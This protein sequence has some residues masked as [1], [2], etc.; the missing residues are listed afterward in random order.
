[1]ANLIRNFLTLLFTVF[2]LTTSPVL[3]F[4]SD[5]LV[6]SLRASLKIAKSDSVKAEISLSL[7]SYTLSVDYKESL[8]YA[9]Q[10]VSFAMEAKSHL[11]LMKGYKAVASVFFYMGVYDKA[12]SFFE[13]CA[14]EAAL[15]NEKF[16][17][18]NCQIN[19]ALIYSALRQYQRAIAI[20]EN[21]QPRLETAYKKAGKE[22]PVADLISIKLN[23]AYNYE[24]LKE[25]VKV[26]P[27]ADSGILLAKQNPDQRSILA[28]LLQLKAKSLL[29]EQKASQA[30]L[31]LKEAETILMELNDQPSLIML[32]S[33][34]GKSFEISNDVVAA[35]GAYK[36]G[37][38][39]A[40]AVS[41]LSMKQYYAEELY[42]VYQSKGLAD[43]AIKYLN[44]FNAYQKE[45]NA[46]K[47][48]EDLLRK[49][50]LEEFTKREAAL[51]KEQAL[52]KNT[53]TYLIA[54]SSVLLLILGVG[55]FFFRNK[56][57]QSSLQKLKLKLEAERLMLE[58]QR[59]QAQLL[60]QEKQLADFEYKLSKNALL[61]ELVNELQ[62]FGA[63]EPGKPDPSSSKSEVLNVNQQGKIWDEFEIRFLKSHAGFYDRLLSAHP[64]LTTNERRLCSFLR[65][66]MTT[67]E[68]SVITGQTVRAVEIARTRLRKKLNMTQA[69][70]SLFDYLST[71]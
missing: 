4:A 20:F 49:E 65:L 28:K 50:L 30:T 56:Y 60:H 51:I 45:A 18:L 62:Q 42:K 23:L 64:D 35:L 11:Q 19:M 41:S 68:I 26:Y 47:A 67:K 46:D 3:L 43:S 59:L 31:L 32:K 63:T 6:D 40:V 22:I 69:D 34:W 15:S 71:I 66:D 33:L 27:L 61:E 44:L 55:L 17:E 24:A 5:P 39:G 36:A 12:I 1:M 57:K 70:K 13:L 10:A 38:N 29:S 21:G 7:A 53:F 16:E 25:Y 48:K 9:Q 2:F 54:V 8:Q 52:Q 37:Y 14:K 58:Q